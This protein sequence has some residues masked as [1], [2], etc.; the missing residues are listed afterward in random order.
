MNNYDQALNDQRMMAMMDDNIDG[1]LQK[2][3]LKGRLGGMIAGYFTAIDTNKD[4]VIEKAELTAAQGMMGNQRR[5]AP[6][7]AAQG[8]QDATAGGK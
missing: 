2:A 5:R 3:E 4:G 8:T 6:A 1:K 7:T